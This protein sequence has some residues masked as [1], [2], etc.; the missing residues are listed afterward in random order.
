MAVFVAGLWQAE[1]AWSRCAEGDDGKVCFDYP[2]YLPYE[3]RQAVD[4][5]WMPLVPLAGLGVLPD[6]ISSGSSKN[7]N[8][9]AVRMIVTVLVCAGVWWMLGRWAE[10]LRSGQRLRVARWAV[11]VGGAVLVSGSLFLVQN[12]MRAGWHGPMMTN[13]GFVMP[14][15]VGV[16]VLVE[17]GVAPR[18]LRPW[19]RRVVVAGLLACG[20]WWAY[21]VVQEKDR[22]RAEIERKHDAEG[23]LRF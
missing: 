15:F 1:R 7:G 11:S 4:L 20:Y 2:Q 14:V 6:C 13:S 3:T 21:S 8:W 19:A 23:G 9:Q 16:L 10:R 5:H 18:M 12:A 17:L 22:E